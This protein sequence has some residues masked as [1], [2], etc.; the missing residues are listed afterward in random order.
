MLSMDVSP[1]K[2]H[3]CWWYHFSNFI[4]PSKMVGISIMLKLSLGL[5]PDAQ[6]DPT[7]L[8]SIYKIRAH[9]FPR[10]SPC[11]GVH[12]SSFSI[13][14]RLN[15]HSWGSGS[16][17]KVRPL[18]SFHLQ[19]GNHLLTDHAT[20]SNDHKILSLRMVP[21]LFGIYPDSYWPLFSKL[22]HGINQQKFTFT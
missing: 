5:P 1:I 7:T 3:I 10:S 14:Q 2:A 18:S 13:S 9:F 4:F 20:W 11:F 8:V 15:E 22:L 6:G 17:K 19:L 21:F 12:P 16:D